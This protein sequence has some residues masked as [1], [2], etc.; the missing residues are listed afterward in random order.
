MDISQST[1]SGV[2]DSWFERMVKCIQSEGGFFEKTGVDIGVVSVVKKTRLQSM[3]DPRTLLQVATT[4]AL[5]MQQGSKRMYEQ[6]R[7]A[8]T[9]DIPGPP[10]SWQGRHTEGL[11]E[12]T[13]NGPIRASQL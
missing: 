7:Q 8:S 6:G 1:W 4:A 11:E 12:L 3:S 10:T 13:Q 2:I 9:T 5:T